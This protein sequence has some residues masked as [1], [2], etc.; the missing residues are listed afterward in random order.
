M[1]RPVERMLKKTL[2]LAL[3]STPGTTL[4]IRDFLPTLAVRSFVN[5][6]PQNEVLTLIFLPARFCT[7][8]PVLHPMSLDIY[9]LRTASGISVMKELISKPNNDESVPKRHGPYNTLRVFFGL[10]S[11]ITPEQ[12]KVEQL[13]DA[14]N[15]TYDS[16]TNRLRLIEIPATKLTFSLN[17]PDLPLLPTFDTTADAFY[18]YLYDKAAASAQTKIATTVPWNYSVMLDLNKAGLVLGIE[19]IVCSTL[20]PIACAH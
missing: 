6:Q 17:E 2:S 1:E 10:P 18:L 14:V 12:V 16:T 11:P 4:N 5:L 15:M 20:I 8:P 9:V 19:V 7:I 3:P 13:V